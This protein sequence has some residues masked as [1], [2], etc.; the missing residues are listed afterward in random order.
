MTRK[1]KPVKPLAAENDAAGDA[2]KQEDVKVGAAKKEAKSANWAFIVYPDSAPADWREVLTL[3]GL[4]CAVSPL[5][6]KDV[7]DEKEEEKKAHW[8]VIMCWDGGSTTFATAR[9]VAALVNGTIPIPL[10]S[11]RGYYRYFTHKDHPKKYQYDENEIVTLNGFDVTDFMGLTAH[12]ARRITKILL[13]Y[14]RD[15]NVT[16]YSDFLFTAMEHF[17]DE[18]FDVARNNTIMFNAVIKSMK[19]RNKERSTNGN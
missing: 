1:P 16:E 15:N 19:H 6:D 7:N 14:I 10:V 9:R 11:V 18:E 12:E 2:K 8:H 3:Q 13:T 5:H 4:R 17:T